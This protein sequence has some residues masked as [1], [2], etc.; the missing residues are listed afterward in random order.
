MTAAGFPPAPI[1]QSCERVVIRV[2]R[3]ALL[4]AGGI[5]TER[6]VCSACLCHIRDVF[7]TPAPWIEAVKA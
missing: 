5:V 7:P 6:D 3:V 1:C 2:Q 4:V